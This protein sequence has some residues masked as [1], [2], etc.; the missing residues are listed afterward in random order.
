MDLKQEYLKN[1]P[2][3]HTL[4]MKCLFRCRGTLEEL[5]P[6]Q[7]GLLM[8]LSEEGCCNQRA[9]VRKMHCSAASVATSIKRLEKSG[10]VKKESDPEDLRSTRI[11]LTELGKNLALESMRKIDEFGDVQ[12]AGFSQEEIRQLVEFQN[13]IIHNMKDFLKE[14]EKK[15]E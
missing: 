4:T 8:T 15:G 1:D 5:H 10:Y 3:L 6:A 7:M 11:V 9:L 12:L 14:S 2:K 13:R